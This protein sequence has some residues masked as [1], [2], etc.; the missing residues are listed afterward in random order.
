VFDHERYAVKELMDLRKGILDDRCGG[1]SSIA[2]EYTGLERITGEAFLKNISLGTFTVSTEDP[3]IESTFEISATEETGG[4]LDPEIRLV[5]DGK[6]VAKINTSC[7]KPI[8]IGD[9]HGDFTIDDLEKLPPKNSGRPVSQEAREVAQTAIDDLVTADRLL[10]Q[11]ML[12]ETAGLAAIN[13]ARQ[14]RVDE[15]LKKAEDELARGDA[16]RDALKP[17]KAIH[18]YRKSWEHAQNAVE[19]AAKE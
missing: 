11:V 2:L 10:A 9:V 15:E 17:D 4:K 1:V 3:D 5:V 7:S 16:D 12:D 18:D 19:E 6:N 8:N 14:T 13:P